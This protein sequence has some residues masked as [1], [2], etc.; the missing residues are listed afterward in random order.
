M[1]PMRNLFLF[2]FLLFSFRSQAQNLL[3]NA[4]FEDENICTEF[5]KNC[6]PEG[7]ISTSLKSDYY[8]DD[9][10]NAHEGGHF[11]GLMVTGDIYTPK[12]HNYVRS[13]LLCGLRAGS[14]YRF[15]CFVRSSHRVLDSVGIYFSDDDILY[16]KEGMKNAV[17][18]LWIRPSLQEPESKS[19]R[20]VSLEY[21]A[22]G[23]ERFLSIGDFMKK[24]H[25]LLNQPDLGIDF[26]FFVDDVS[27]VP[28]NPNEKICPDTERIKEEE[29]ET[30]ERHALLEKKVYRYS[31][32]P[33]ELTAATV[34]L[35]QRIDTLVIPDVLFATNSYALNKKANA[36]LD[37]FII[38]A[39]ALHVDSLVVEGHTDS[40]G[41]ALVNEKLSQNRAASV[42]SYLQPHFSTG[43][44]ARGRASEKPVADNR[45]A[46]GRKRNRRVEVYLY[47]RE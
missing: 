22:T 42:A 29:Y 3:M 37:S 28:I 35:L 10:R 15:E 27:L 26:Y 40:T 12:P 4:G 34:T 17:P 32:T 41:S 33:P 39:R 36:I 11:I 19:W 7:W 1:V 21:V 2:I 44:I 6:A 14:H 13:R 24:P 23:N 9:R 16:R 45:T 18:Q 25:P 20:K 43:I 38:G 8:F 31:K 46:A 47:I 30:N 5:I